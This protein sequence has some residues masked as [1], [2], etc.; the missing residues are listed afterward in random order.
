[1]EL[2]SVVKAIFLL[3]NLIGNVNNSNGGVENENCNSLFR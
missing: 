1:M 2:E 3:E